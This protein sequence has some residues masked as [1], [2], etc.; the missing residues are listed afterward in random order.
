MPQSRVSV[1]HYGQAPQNSHPT[2]YLAGPS[3]FK[4]PRDNWHDEAVGLFGRRSQPVNLLIPS[5]AGGDWQDGSAEA[6]LAQEEWQDLWLRQATIR[7]Y[8]APWPTFMTY[9]EL[10]WTAR[11]LAV[12]GLSP[13]NDKPD[14]IRAVARWTGLPLY[15]NLPDAV[16]AVVIKLRTL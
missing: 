3:R 6:G 16:S 1:F 15:D 12:L 14:P 11:G 7:L 5:P 9:G 13:T 8:Y 10:W 4:T 2:V